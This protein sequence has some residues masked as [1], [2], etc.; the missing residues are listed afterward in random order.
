MPAPKDPIKYQKW[1]RKISEARN[2][3]LVENVMMNFTKYMEK[4]TT[5]KNN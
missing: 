3:F 5:Q 4:I 2:R 1:R